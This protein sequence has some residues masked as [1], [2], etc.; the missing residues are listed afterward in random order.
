MGVATANK[1]IYRRVSDTVS[2]LIKSG[3]LVLAT[4]V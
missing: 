3:K 2:N 1:E 4:I